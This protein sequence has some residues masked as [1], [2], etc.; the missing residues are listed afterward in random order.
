MAISRTI[1]ANIPY[2]L[3]TIRLLTKTIATVL[4]NSLTMVCKYKI[5]GPH[6]ISVQLH[7]GDRNITNMNLFISILLLIASP[8][9]AD[10]SDRSDRSKIAD[11][12]ENSVSD[13]T[14][15]RNKSNFSFNPLYLEKV[16]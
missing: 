13:K 12:L 8:C 16:N 5:L 9:L 15:E 10:N 4:R 11:S 1:T 14:N 6:Y 3:L 2:S 7:F